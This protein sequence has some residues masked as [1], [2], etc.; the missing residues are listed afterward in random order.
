MPDTQLVLEDKEAIDAVAAAFFDAFTTTGGRSPDVDSLYRL[1]IERAVIVSNV[2]GA[3][4]VYDVTTFVEPRRSI[5]TNGT[6]LEFR[7]EEVSEQTTIAGNI[8]QRLSRYRKWWIEAG[9][10]REG[11]GTKSLQFVRTAE[12]WKIA[13]LIWDDD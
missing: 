8:A 4:Q 12:G 6:L 1:F 3:M 7:E 11:G 13:S 9:A 10:K 5:L 2:R